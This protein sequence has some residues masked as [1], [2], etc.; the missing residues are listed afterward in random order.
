L[1]VTTELEEHARA[2]VGRMTPAERLRLLAGDHD[3]HG[4]M[5]SGV[6]DSYRAPLWSAASV[7]RLGLQGLRFVDGPRGVARGMSTCFPVTMA[8]AA[9]S[10]ASP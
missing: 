10:V 7:P 3:L 2:L 6:G 9:P 5:L 1:A 4:D 8:R